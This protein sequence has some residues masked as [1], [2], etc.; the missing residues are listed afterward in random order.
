MINKESITR[1]LR[2]GDDSADVTDVQISSDTIE[3][4]LQKKDQVMFCPE[5]GCR[6]E[7]K[8]IRVRKVNHPVMQD[9][10]KLILHVK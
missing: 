6:M 3:V 5:C 4:T 7:S 10:Y 9:G 8:C 1:I 2:L